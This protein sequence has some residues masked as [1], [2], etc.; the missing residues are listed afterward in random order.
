MTTN[1]KRAALCHP[2]STGRLCRG[3]HTIFYVEAGNPL[4]PPVVVLHGGPGS[5]SQP[6]VLRLFDLTRVRVVLVDQRGTGMSTPRGGTR[7]NSTKYLIGDLEALREELGIERWGVLGGSWGGALALAYAGR[8]PERVLGLVL[9]GLFMTSKREVRGFFTTSRYRAPQEWKRLATA[10][11]TSRSDRLPLQ[12]ARRL[13]PGVSWV[14]RRA[15]A[16]SWH[17]YEEA[18]LMRR[19]SREERISRQKANRLIDKYRIQ[20][21]Y[22]QHGCWLGERKLRVL[23]RSASHA[24]V[25]IFVAHGN[26]DP[27]CPIKNVTRLERAVSAVVVE[28]VAAGHLASR[29]QLAQS[30]SRLIRAM[31]A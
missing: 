11:G 25:P 20:S 26:H 30:V 24:G 27:V 5:G 1:A 17:R 21:H 4:G 29:G 23:A 28:C 3:A 18:I 7:H 15:V 12:C 9:R 16:L 6:G 19:S 2:L 10:A 31:L 8:F 22:L 13:Q 14:R